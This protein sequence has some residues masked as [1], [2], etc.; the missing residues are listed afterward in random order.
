MKD[1]LV[2]P[3]AG[4]ALG[5]LVSHFT[6]FGVRETLLA[7]AAFSALAALS[8]WR[9]A[10]W[11]TLVSG[12]LA[13]VSAGILDDVLHRPGPPPELDASSQEIVILDGCV[14][15]PSTLYENREQFTLEL[16]PGA[17]AHVSFTLRDGERAPS[18][19]YGQR[20]EIEAHVR[21]P[22]NFNNPGSFDYVT[23]L[24]RQTVYWTAA[25]P[26]GGKIKVLPG[27]CGSRFFAAI[28]A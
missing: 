8:R 16:A 25:I 13:I 4:L 2:A 5:I 14:V 15:E 11:L 21:R 17:R 23:Y 6:H 1:P 22:R 18:L 19:N 12:A 28:F 20:L 10:R 24:A 7:V 3:L 26:H 27:R 9:R